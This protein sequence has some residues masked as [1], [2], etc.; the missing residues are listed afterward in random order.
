MNNEDRLLTKKEVGQMLLLGRDRTNE[1][2][3]QK[4]FPAVRFNKTAFVYESDL[5]AYL[6]SHRGKTVYL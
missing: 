4:D 1:L 2:F 6:K 5:H 3:K